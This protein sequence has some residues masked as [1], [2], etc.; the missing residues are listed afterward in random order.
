MR[1]DK[2]MR[3]P[4]LEPVPTRT[5]DSE[6]ER[7]ERD[8]Q[9]FIQSGGQIRRCEVGATNYDH[10]KVKFKISAERA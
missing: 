2:L 9:R 6:R 10:A 7:L 8:V 4:I 5:K 3:F 1:S